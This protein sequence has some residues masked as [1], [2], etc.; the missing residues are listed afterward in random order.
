[1]LKVISGNVSFKFPTY[2][3]DYVSSYFIKNS[4]L[5]LNPKNKFYKKKPPKIEELWTQPN[6]EIILCH[7]IIKSIRCILARI[8]K[9]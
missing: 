8:R 2:S 4:I 7:K 1:M 5:E 3:L 6:Q 9:K